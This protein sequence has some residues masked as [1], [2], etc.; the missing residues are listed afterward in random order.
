MYSTPSA[1]LKMMGSMKIELVWPLMSHE[2]KRGESMALPLESTQLYTRADAG[3]SEGLL[4]TTKK[5]FACSCGGRGQL[6]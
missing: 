5:M 1:T 3:L 2:G 4:S 6:G